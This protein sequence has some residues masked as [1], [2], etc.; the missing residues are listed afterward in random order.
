M[1]AFWMHTDFRKEQILDKTPY[2]APGVSLAGGG[3]GDRCLAEASLRSA[4]TREE[5]RVCETK[6]SGGEHGYCPLIPLSNPKYRGVL[7]DT[8]PLLTEAGPKG[9]NHKTPRLLVPRGTGGVRCVEWCRHGP[10]E[11][12]FFLKIGLAC[13]PSSSAAA[14][15]TSRPARPSSGEEARKRDAYGGTG[16]SEYYLSFTSPAAPRRRR[17]RGWRR[18]RGRRSPPSRRP[19]LSC[20]TA[21]TCS[22]ARRPR[23]AT[24]LRS[25]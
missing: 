20:A 13:R 23:F 2:P 11:P 14:S 1:R 7:A 15:P 21:C 6:P 9:A 5:I 3:A 24:S 12:M 10:K 8:R 18:R 16:N 25:R 17:R 4:D 19:P 22:R